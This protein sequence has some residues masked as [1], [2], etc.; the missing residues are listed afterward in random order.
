MLGNNQNIDML[1]KSINNFSWLQDIILKKIYNNNNLLL[2]INNMKKSKYQ[3]G[4]E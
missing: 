4:F 2:I 3:S 1:N